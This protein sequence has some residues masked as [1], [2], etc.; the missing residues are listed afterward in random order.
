M[1]LHE[2]LYE[3]GLRILAF[4][5]NQFGRQE[6]GSAMEIRRF[7][8]GYN[9]QFD[10]FEKTKVNGADAHP[11]YKYLKSHLSDVLGSSIKWNF[12]KFLVDKDGQPV[13]RYG[14]TTS[15]LSIKKDI[16]ALLQAMPGESPLRRKASR[17]GLR[18][19]S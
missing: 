4:P 5:C 8:D 19:D 10:F 15:P 2:A 18:A 1:Q 7:A 6:K 17:K 9:A 11:V 12:T 13:R 14:P 3:R 16:E